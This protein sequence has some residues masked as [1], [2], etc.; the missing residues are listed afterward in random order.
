M[1][2]RMYFQKVRELERSLQDPFV[3][4]V[5][6]DTSDGGKAGVTTEVSRFRAC[7]LVVEGKARLATKEETDT[8]TEEGWQARTA[9]EQAL[10]ATKVQFVT[11]SDHEAKMFRKL[12][13]S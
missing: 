3:V 10:A 13:S 9:A 6:L 2:I 11:L 8:H 4:V 5:S 12:K 7:Q 1:D